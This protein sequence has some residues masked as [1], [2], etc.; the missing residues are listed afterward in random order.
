MKAMEKYRSGNNEIITLTPAFTKELSNAGTDWIQKTAA[1][2]KADGKP[3]MSDVLG[4]YD[5][6]QKRWKAENDYLIK[7]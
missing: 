5:S 1:K 3:R 7:D 6:Y 2:Q 4:S